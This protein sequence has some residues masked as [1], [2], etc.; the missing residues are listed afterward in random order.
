MQSGV[1]ADNRKPSEQT[2]KLDQQNRPPPSGRDPSVRP[3]G[4][5]RTGI[6]PQ[7]EPMKRSN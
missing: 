6:T 5:Y 4:E 2:D 3:P 7:R 1:V